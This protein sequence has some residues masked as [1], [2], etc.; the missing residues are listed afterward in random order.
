MSHR[1]FDHAVESNGT[2]ITPPKGPSFKLRGAEYQ[3]VPVLPGVALA[4]IVAAAKGSGPE[5]MKAAMDFF[6][7]AMTDDDLERL[8]SAFRR[9]EVEFVVALPEIM[10]IFSWLVTE[11]GE[12]PT[13]GS[14]GSPGGPKITGRGLTVGRPLET[15]TP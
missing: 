8:M 11:Y 12:N 15:S 7:L 1:D 3:C 6:D 9:K 13:L 4:N 2:P 5:Q 10:E 14:N